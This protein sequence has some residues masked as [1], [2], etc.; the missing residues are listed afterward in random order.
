MSADSGLLALWTRGWALTRG[1]APPVWDEGGWRIEVGEPDQ[2]RRYVHAEVDAA[3]ARRAERIDQPRVFLKVCADEATTVAL[4]PRRWSV[5][6]PGF[7][8]TLSGPMTPGP[9]DDDG[10]RFS[11]ERRGPV[12]HC[13]VFAGE[14]EVA[15]GRVVVVEGAVAVYDR[16]VVDPDHRRRGLGRRMMRALEGQAGV[17]RGVLVATAEGRPLYAALGWTLHS[18]YTTAVL[19]G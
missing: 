11:L 18:H 15:R 4:L 9:E 3:L 19:E 16:I 12:I 17:R 6:P 5:R 2:L 14:V 10:Y 7:M 8:M 1:L 13:F